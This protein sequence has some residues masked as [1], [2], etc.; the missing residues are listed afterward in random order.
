VFNADC[1]G[2]ELLKGASIRGLSYKFSTKLLIIQE[3]S[4]SILHWNIEM[5]NWCTLNFSFL[6]ETD[7]RRTQIRKVE[8]SSESISFHLFSRGVGLK[9]LLWPPFG[10]GQ[11]DFSAAWTWIMDRVAFSCWHLRLRQLLLTSA[12]WFGRLT[13][14]RGE[15]ESGIE[16]L[17]VVDAAGI[18]E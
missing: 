15:I 16:L 8:S 14:L 10:K 4:D 12:A 11:S 13:Q 1:T 2:V 6:S 3:P 5:L 17:F 18:S 9:H 7:S